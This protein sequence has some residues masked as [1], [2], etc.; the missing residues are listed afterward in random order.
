MLYKLNK[1]FIWNNFLNINFLNGIDSVSI[2]FI[3]LVVFL[4]N[5]SLLSTW[6]NIKYK[7]KEFV[8]LL[9]LVESILILFFLTNDLFFFYI[10]FE[11]VLIPMFLIIGIWG[12]RA[13]KIH[14]VYV[15][16]FYTFVGSMLMLFGILIIYSS[17]QNLDIMVLLNVY[18]DE[19]R[20]KLL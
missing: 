2:I 14:A 19:D 15:F 13:R 4:I 8:L 9:F 7:L 1:H 16:F 12:S 11:S 17:A 6:N 10:F 20:Q 5:L 18:Y 3:L